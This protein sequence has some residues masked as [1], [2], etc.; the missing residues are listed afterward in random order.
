MAMDPFDAIF[1]NVLSETKSINVRY[2]QYLE[3]LCLWEIIKAMHFAIIL[4]CMYR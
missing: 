2:V 4:G 3:C 1:T